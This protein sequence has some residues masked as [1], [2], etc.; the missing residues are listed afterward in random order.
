MQKDT[1]ESCLIYDLI[2][3]INVFTYFE[4]KK[5]N[6]YHKNNKYII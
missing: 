2:K 3:N 4:E 6:I 5:N 1:N